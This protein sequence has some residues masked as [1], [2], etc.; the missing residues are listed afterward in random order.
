VSPLA[1][2][3][4]KF[5]EFASFLIEHSISVYTNSSKI[6]TDSIVGAAVFSPELGLALKHKLISDSSIF[7]EEAWPIYQALILIE[8]SGY[9]N[10]VIFSDSRRF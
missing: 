3:C 2:I 9:H 7:T 10:S 5:R 4:A 8:G 6:D 1:K